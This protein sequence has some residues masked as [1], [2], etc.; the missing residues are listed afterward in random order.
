MTKV[1]YLGKIIG[2]GE[3]FPVLEKIST[4]EYI[5]VPKTKKGIE[6]SFKFI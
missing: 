6:V 4:V 2:S 1:K 3:H 5:K